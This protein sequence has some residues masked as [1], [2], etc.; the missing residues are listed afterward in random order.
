MM[1]LSIVDPIKKSNRLWLLTMGVAF[2]FLACGGGSGTQGSG[3]V[4]TGSIT[5]GM[6]WQGEAPAVNI[7]RSLSGDI[8][9]DYLIDTIRATLYDA[10]GDTV[11]AASIAC[12]QHS[13]TLD[14]IPVGDG[15]RVVGEGQVAGEA[16]WRGETAGINVTI[17]PPTEATTIAMSYQCM[18]ANPPFVVATQP[19]AGAADLPHTPTLTATFSEA[20]AD[21]TLSAAS[22]TLFAG[23]TQVPGDIAYDAD[24][25]TASL[26]PREALAP[27]TTYTATLTTAIEDLDGS[28]M[29]EAYTWTFSTGSFPSYTIDATTT[30]GG[31]IDPAGAVVVSE[32]S[33]PTFT[34][35]ADAG[36]FIHAVTVNG[37]PVAVGDSYRFAAVTADQTL[38]VAFRRVWYVDADL[39][40]GGDGRTWTTA[41]NTIQGALTQAV[42]GDEIWVKN[43]TYL[44]TTQLAIN[45]AIFVRGGFAGSESHPSH[46]AGDN[47]A[48]SIDGN[49]TVRCLFIAGDAYLDG[50]NLQNG[51]ISGSTPQGGAIFIDAA[52]P[53]IVDCRILDNTA[54]PSD[55][56]GGAVYVNQGA[57]IFQNC[58]FEGNRVSGASSSYGGAVYVYRSDTRFIACNFI[59]NDSAGA[60][61][62]YGGAIYNASSSTTI[63]GCRFAGNTAS[64][65]GGYG[66]AIYNSS[67]PAQISACLF[68]ANSAGGLS[69]SGGAIFNLESNAVIENCGFQKNRAGGRYT[70]NGGGI[71][72]SGS[73][74]A[75]INCTLFQN[76]VVVS[77]GG[78]TA[79]GGGVYNIS[80]QPTVIN[81]ILWGNTAAND[82]DNTL[83][84][85]SQI[86]D[87][88][89]A[90]ATVSH[91]DIDQNGYTG[92]G[93]L[94]R[95]PL[96]ATDL[97]LR[98]GS[99]CIAQADTA[100][101]PTLDVDDEDRPQGVAA[102]MGFDEFL[103]TDGDQM[104]DFWEMAH[105]LD[106]DQADADGD[107]DADGLT[108]L[109]EYILASH[110]HEANPVIDAA[111]RGHYRDDGFH[112]PPDDGTLL[113]AVG[114]SD[115]R[116][117][118]IFDLGGL[119]GAVAAASLRL[120]L[121][122]YDS[123]DPS[124]SLEF[125]AITTDASLLE[126]SSGSVPIYDDLGDGNALGRWTFSPADV[127][128][129]LEIPLDTAAV[130]E[131]NAAAGSSFAVGVAL[132][133]YYAGQ[134]VSFS[135][136][137]EPRVHQLV[138]I[139]E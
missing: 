47:Y 119:S 13:L 14:R 86:Y 70:A 3:S 7:P 114:G 91:C 73:D 100:S 59:D 138:L 115:Y 77:E 129:V 98:A 46:R 4:S 135:V 75:I 41:F 89:D 57:P 65:E 51:A 79:Y 126:T 22:F 50:L 63:F 68:S 74:V 139:T 60:Y 107:P 28:P 105:E 103:D 26:I 130:A 49:G 104:P 19:A 93:N 9:R 85:F 2:L 11:T 132:D 8:C 54:G 43:G 67:S 72:N 44:L 110:P 39:G 42:S 118:F 45:T 116:S 6:I 24:N 61:G 137:G 17:D 80:S 87:H 52:S 32:G 124:E 66:G 106:T 35:T 29:A 108:N 127:G 20:L 12:D 76:Q 111:Q 34:F 15:Y 101:T 122:A 121:V 71:S 99:P 123:I 92:N 58:V 83:S 56:F 78:E 134:T 125:W 136:A 62:D 23:A 112:D 53:T 10:G 128:R 96:L 133:D 40:G 113:G 27:E 94:R 30:V 1:R 90:S 5:L 38:N 21:A 109:S 25:H 84:H 48:T 64:G 131:I 82:I 102:D 69:G 117:Y 31:S 33:R 97:H 18:D 81:S 95:P 88:T 55:A 120:E 37:T 36:Y 16:C